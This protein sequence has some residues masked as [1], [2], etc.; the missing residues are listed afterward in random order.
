MKRKDG[1][2]L[3]TKSRDRLIRKA[4]P[5]PLS[6]V[7]CQKGSHRGHFWGTL[8]H[9][10][11]TLPPLQASLSASL[12]LGQ[13]RPGAPSLLPTPPPRKPAL[14]CWLTLVET[15]LLLPRRHHLLLHS[16]PLWA[17]HLPVGA[18]PILMPSAAVPALL[19]LEASLLRAKPPSRPSQCPQPVGC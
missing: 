11:Q 10:S 9:L 2:S 8:C 1:T 12:R 3:Q 19:L 5:P 4:V 14:T 6:R 13:L 18:S 17:R 16:Q 15:P 7:P